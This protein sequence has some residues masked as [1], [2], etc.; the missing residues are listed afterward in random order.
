[1]VSDKMIGRAGYGHSGG[2]EPHFEPP[3]TLFAGTIRVSDQRMDGYSPA[4]GI[5]QGPLDLPLFEPEDYDLDVATRA[6]DCL[7]QRPNSVPRLYQ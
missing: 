6:Y 7:Y 3:Q 1:M 2:Q 5:C 4:D